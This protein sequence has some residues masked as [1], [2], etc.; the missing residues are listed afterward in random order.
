M[1][2]C[3]GYVRKYACT[4][5]Y[6]STYVCTYVRMYM[7]FY[8]CT[9]VRRYEC[10]Y[11]RLYVCMHACLLACFCVYFETMDMC[12]K[13]FQDDSPLPG[14]S[15]RRNHSNGASIKQ[16]LNKKQKAQWIHLGDQRNNPLNTNNKIAG[17]TGIRV[18]LPLWFNLV[19]V[20]CA[21]L[22]FPLVGNQ[23]LP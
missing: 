23:G 20:F 10:T 21:S 12:R 2:V 8:V 14:R 13:P 22:V 11:V 5:M 7:H 6:A 1:Y 4:I 15:E 18:R 16:V 9:Y 19:L 17:Y 3:A